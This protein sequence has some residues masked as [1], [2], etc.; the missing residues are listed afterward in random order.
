MSAGV[1]ARRAACLCLNRGAL[2]PVLSGLLVSGLLATALPARAEEPGKVPAIVQ[3]LRTFA[4]TATKVS[5]STPVKLNGTAIP[6]GTYELFTIPGATQW[7]VIIH[8]NMS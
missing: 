4:N 7:T 6:A 5:F 1:S 2:T 3:Q 8:K